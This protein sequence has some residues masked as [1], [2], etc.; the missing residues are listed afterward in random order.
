MAI[1]RVALLRNAELLL[2]RGKLDQAI[3]EY[4]RIVDAQPRDWTTAIVLGDLYLRVRQVDKAVETYVR[5][6]HNLGLEGFWS[7]A[8]ALYK[9]ILKIRPQD[10]YLL[11]QAAE[12]AAHQELLVE[13]RQYLS[14]VREQRRS[15]GDAAGVAAV[16]IRLAALDPLDFDMRLAGVRAQLEIGEVADAVSGLKKLASDLNDVGQRDQALAA[17]QQGA[18]LA[19]ADLEIR[20]SI[21]RISGAE[22]PVDS[23]V[24]EP[25]SA[26]EPVFVEESSPPPQSASTT[27]DLDG[28]FA[29]LREE[30][31]QRFATNNP[32]Q[33]LVA[34]VAFYR[35][36]QLDFAV[37][38]L[39]AASRSSAHRFEAAA[40]L[41]RIFLERGDAWRAIEWL[42]RAAEVPAPAPADTHRLLYELADALEGVGEVARALAICL[43]L[44]AEAGDYQDVSARVDRLVKVQARG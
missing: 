6:A 20:N 40:T 39:E 9:K 23:P 21:A 16:T 17:L 7:K 18:D 34:G 25:V 41:G 43:E 11:L 24:T 37:P 5:V 27:R 30:A 2:Q 28:V 15:R 38:R 1:D 8:G 35:A 44:Q 33:E 3:A 13:A 42:E 12:M 31:T 36:G 10:E 22:P 29:D 26:V 4:R 19:P 32:E 14:T